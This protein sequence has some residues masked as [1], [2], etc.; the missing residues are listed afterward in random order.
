MHFQT[1]G[2]I[3]AREDDTDRVR[4]KHALS[5]TRNHSL[6]GLHNLHDN[7]QNKI[8]D[9]VIQLYKQRV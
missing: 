5:E 3:L 6:Y 8:Q 1:Q 7:Y 4:L 2:T 9:L